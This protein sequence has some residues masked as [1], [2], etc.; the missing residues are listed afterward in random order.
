MSDHR[1]SFKM[2]VVSEAAPERELLRRAA[3]DAA[4]PVEFAETESA[5]DP[6]PACALLGE[7]AVDFIFLDSRMPKAGRQAVLDAARAA[8]GR[9]LVVLIGPAILKT[10][11]VLS[12]GLAVDG[13]LAKPI[14]LAEASNV[15]NVCCRGRLPKNVL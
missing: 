7:Q 6:A 11:E 13:V 4:F 10:R 8:P 12:D 15:I 9:P 1:V 3:L 5:T 2:V 14:E